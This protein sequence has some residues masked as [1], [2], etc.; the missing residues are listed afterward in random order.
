MRL[1]MGDLYPGDDALRSD[2]NKVKAR[3]IEL[4]TEPAKEPQ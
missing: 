2:L 4:F 1:Q 3:Y